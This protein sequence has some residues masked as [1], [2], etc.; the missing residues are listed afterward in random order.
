MTTLISVFLIRNSNFLQAA[1]FLIFH[2][3]EPGSFLI[4]QF[5]KFVIPVLRCV[6]LKV[7]DSRLYWYELLVFGLYLMFLVF[8]LLTAE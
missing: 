6:G 2:D 7:I 1:S 8:L 5:R 4:N 3:F